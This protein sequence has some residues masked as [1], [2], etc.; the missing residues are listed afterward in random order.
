MPKNC[1]A[2]HLRSDITAVMIAPG[3]SSAHGCN[4]R[5]LSP[6]S[7]EPVLLGGGQRGQPS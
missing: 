6:L 3:E 4:N 1:P 5:S 7:E 2:P